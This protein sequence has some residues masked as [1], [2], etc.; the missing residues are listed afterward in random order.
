MLAQTRIRGVIAA[1]A[2]PVDDR[3]EPD[4]R[5]LVEHARWLLA[6]GCDGLNVLG[7]TGGFASFSVAQRVRVM[8]AFAASGLDL[9]AMMAGTGAS[10]FADTVALTEAAVA[11]GFGGALVIPPFYY[12]N[13]TEDG[14]FAYVANLIERTGSDGLRLYLYNFPALSGVPYTVP[15]V[16][17]LLGAYPGIVAG[18]KDSSN[19]AAYAAA[20]HEAFPQLDVFPSSEAVLAA[21]RRSGYAGCISATVNLTAPLAGRVWNGADDSRTGALQRELGAIRAAIGSVPLIPAVH[22]L[23]G[24]LRRENVWSRLNPPLHPLTAG[25][26][27]AL[28]RAL[29]ATSYRTE[30]E[31]A[32]GSSHTGG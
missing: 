30:L 22:H 5:A 2:T 31:V 3:L 27:A 28:E 24:E 17:R 8:E 16:G 21:A 25:E 7:T 11:L 10:A 23:V 20:L 4:V 15:L 1:V 12:K 13:V 19:D 32:T 26:R 29:A 9:G 18:L 14:V 6:H